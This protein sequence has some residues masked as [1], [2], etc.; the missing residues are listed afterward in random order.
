ME[1]IVHRAAGLDVHKD[2]IAA[3]VHLPGNVR[4]AAGR[5][6]GAARAIWPD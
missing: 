1:R 6:R 3:E 4:P 2:V 5:R